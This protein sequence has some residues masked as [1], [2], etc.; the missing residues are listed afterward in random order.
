MCCVT[1]QFGRTP[2]HIAAMS[3]YPEVCVCEWF[4]DGDNVCIVDALPLYTL[5]CIHAG[6]E[7]L[8]RP[9][10]RPVDSG[11]VGIDGA[12]VCADSLAAI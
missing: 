6:G 7:L 9:R 8:A 10:L 1:T 11:P 5:C 2:L 4:L 3:N 12:V